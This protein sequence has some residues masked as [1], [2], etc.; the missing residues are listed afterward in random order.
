MSINNEQNNMCNG[1]EC[2]FSA[3]TWHNNRKL[4]DCADKQKLEDIEKDK[5]VRAW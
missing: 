5:K 2:V 3:T 4:T 1:Q